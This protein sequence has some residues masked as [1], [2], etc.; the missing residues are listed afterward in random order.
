MYC[1]SSCNCQIPIFRFKKI[2]RVQLVAQYIQT[3]LECHYIFWPTTKSATADSYTLTVSLICDFKPWVLYS[4]IYALF[5]AFV[6]RP[7]ASS[8]YFVDPV[9]C[10]W[11]SANSFVAT[12]QLSSIFVACR[13]DTASWAAALVAHFMDQSAISTLCSCS[14]WTFS[15]FASSAITRS[16]AVV[17]HLCLE[18]SQKWISPK[19]WSFLFQWL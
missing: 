13:T 16:L 5:D 15:I 1:F 12:L 10:F 7:S 2:Q 17:D 11:V 18:C 3:L 6:G 14:C 9:A 8:A 19:Q 4:S